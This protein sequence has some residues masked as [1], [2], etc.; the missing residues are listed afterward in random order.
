MPAV[1]PAPLM[2][3]SCPLCGQPNQCAIA[4]GRPAASCW[5]M[6]Q[7]ID[8]AALAAVPDG[9]RG[10]VCICAACGAPAQGAQQPSAASRPPSPI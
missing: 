5:C 4:A 2:P 3:S 9:A 6:T 10:Q 1:L 8:P 7:A